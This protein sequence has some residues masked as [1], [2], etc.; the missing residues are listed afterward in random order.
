MDFNP[1]DPAF[2]RDPYPHYATLRDQA[3]VY[4]IPNVGIYALSR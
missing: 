4:E 1:L 3:P 2:R